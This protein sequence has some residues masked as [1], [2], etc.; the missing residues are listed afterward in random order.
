VA[1]SPDGKY[2]AYVE[3]V[4]PRQS[5]W[6]RQ[7]AT[8]INLPV[9]AAAEVNYFGLTF[10]TD[11]NYIYF[12]S[13][14]KGGFR[15]LYRVP[16][17]GAGPA[18]KLLDLIDS[19]VT[20][21]PDGK[22]IAFMRDFAEQEETHLIVADADGSNE[23]KLTTR[24]TPDFFVSGDV[25]VK[26]AW[27]P[28]GKVLVCPGG[29]K[30]ANGNYYDVIGV[31]VED[32]SQRSLSDKR[33]ERVLQVTSYRNGFVILGAEKE[34]SSPSLYVQLWFMS[35]PG[36]QVQRIT[37]DTTIYQS[38]S[39]AVD[40][41]TLVTTQKQLISN[42]WLSSRGDTSRAKQLTSGIREGLGSFTWTPGE[43]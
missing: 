32:G 20:F 4:G 42:I 7:L 10:S 23:R 39:L 21:S 6:V 41:Q 14:E 8:G 19:T 36:G 5:L 33:W 40:S 24:K 35:Y 38:V 9:I 29:T 34:E 37:N 11:G 12:V 25:S 15:K 31:S 30:D 13:N 27:T 3:A 22:R 16:A 18:R 26:L 17:L 28:D 1:I 43:K 2:V